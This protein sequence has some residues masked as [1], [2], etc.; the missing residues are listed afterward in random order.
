MLCFKKLVLVGQVVVVVVVVVALLPVL[1]PGLVAAPLL[2][3]ARL[4]LRLWSIRRKEGRRKE[5]G[6]STYKPIL[7]LLAVTLLR[8]K[9]HT[10]VRVRR[11]DK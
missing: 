2:L 4:G 5:K 1:L 3:A 9:S 11:R 6:G 8:M 10:R 7:V